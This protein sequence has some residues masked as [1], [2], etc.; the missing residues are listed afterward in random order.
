MKYTGVAVDFA[1]GTIG[2]SKAGISIAAHTYPA[3]RG[4]GITILNKGKKVF[5][6]EW[7]RFKIP[8]GKRGVLGKKVNRPHIDTPNRKHW[9]W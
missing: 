2:A 5:G 8:S 9:P 7:H 1:A 4:A 3:A 6:I